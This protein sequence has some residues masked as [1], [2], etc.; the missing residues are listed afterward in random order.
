MLRYGRMDVR[1]LIPLYHI[2]VKRLWDRAVNNAASAVE[3]AAA[4]R[5]LSFVDSMD[6]SMELL[7][8]TGDKSQQLQQTLENSTSSLHSIGTDLDLSPL[9]PVPPVVPHLSP[10][11]P[12]SLESSFTRFSFSFS[13]QPSLSPFPLSPIGVAGAKAGGGPTSGIDQIFSQTLSNSRELWLPTIPN[14]NDKKATIKISSLKNKY[15]A[16]RRK[17][18]SKNWMDLNSHIFMRYV[19][20]LLHI[21]PHKHTAHFVLFCQAD[22]MER[23]C[24]L[25]CE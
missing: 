15:E 6:S 4:R 21:T 12:P 16:F 19:R 17:A 14:L 24:C 3:E 10:A 9:P 7:V 2:L 11:S 13:E 8:D 22:S 5:N 1:F 25:S 23:S 20:Q 18:K